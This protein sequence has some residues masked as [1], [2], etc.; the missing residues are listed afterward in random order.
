ME[1]L[2]ER[3]NEKKREARP[4]IKFFA[5]VKE[6]FIDDDNLAM[7]WDYL[8]DWGEEA[9]LLKEVVYD[10]AVHGDEIEAE[11]GDPIHVFTETTI[12]AL[13]LRSKDSN[14]SNGQ[15]GT[16]QTAASFDDTVPVD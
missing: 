15:D 7:D 11:P 6:H 12:N 5:K 8:Q 3:A 9:G 13:G 16:T 14:D 4:F 2:F 10:P 1:C